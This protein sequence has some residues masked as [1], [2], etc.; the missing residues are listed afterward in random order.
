MELLEHIPYEDR[1]RKVGLFSLEKIKLCGDPIATLQYLKDTSGT[2]REAE[3]GFSIK[4]CSDRTRR[5][6]G[7][8]KEVIPIY[9]NY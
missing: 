1:L 9:V 7:K 8:L 2:Y 4:N 6:E 5:K 3:K